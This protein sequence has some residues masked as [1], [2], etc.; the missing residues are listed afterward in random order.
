MA[1][2]LFF[3][4]LGLLIAGAESLVR[5]ASRLAARVGI[6]ALVIG[7][8]VVAFGTSAPELAVSIRSVTTGSGAIAVGNVVGSNIFNILFILGISALITPLTVAGQLIRFDVPFMI[9]VSIM[10]MIFG[11]NGSLSHIEGYALVACFILYT[12][13]L[14]RLS[15]KEPVQIKNEYDDSFGRPETK[16]LRYILQDTILVIGGLGLL[17]FGAELFVKNA[18]SIAR[19]L[20]MSEKVI[21][22]TIV[23]AGTS[24]PEVVTSIVAGIRGQRDIAVGNVIGSN[25]FNLL[26]VLGIAGIVAPMGINIDREMLYFDFP[27]MIATAAICFPVFFTRNLIARWE[28][29]LLLLFYL[30]YTTYLFLAAGRSASLAVYQ[31]ALLYCVIPATITLLAVVMVREMLRRRGKRLGDPH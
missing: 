4:G 9:S 8:T 24:M 14:I 26:G 21:G 3:I 13:V 25:V 28:G 29:A 12:F 16:G 5:G 18:V 2:L 23:A 7:L 6:S 31:S 19:M 1:F 20:G 30:I 22:L 10:A 15:R 27:V 17:V 11:W